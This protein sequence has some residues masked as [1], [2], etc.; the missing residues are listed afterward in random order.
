[1]EL[2]LCIF[3]K[4][5]LIGVIAKGAFTWYLFAVS[6]C[7]CQSLVKRFCT[8]H[9]FWQPATSQ[10]SQPNRHRLDWKLHKTFPWSQSN[11]PLHQKRKRKICPLTHDHSMQ[12]HKT[13]LDEM[14]LIPWSN[15]RRE[16][17]NVKSWFAKD[18]VLPFCKST[19][20]WF[21]DQVS[22]FPLN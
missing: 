15:E 21:G 9:T 8:S 13:Q 2:S 16:E 11:D 1:M 20:I 18:A 19:L 3:C 7:L 22:P 4:L 14:I 12:A 5:V 17:S 10:P 6:F